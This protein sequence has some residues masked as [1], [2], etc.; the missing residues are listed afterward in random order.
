MIKIRCL[1][2]SGSSLQ[3][4]IIVT[5]KSIFDEYSI[6]YERLNPIS[7]QPWIKDI[8]NADI[9]VLR[10]PANRLISL[11][12]SHGW[13]HQTDN[14][15][16]DAFELREEI[17]SQNLASWMTNEGVLGYTNQVY[18][19]IIDLKEECIIRY[20]DIMD[21]GK[22]YLHLLLDKINRLD[23][24]DALWDI[25]SCEFNCNVEDQ[26]DK[27]YN[28]Q[29]MAHRRNLDHKE[30]L[31]KLNNKQLEIIYNEMGD[32]I[33]RYNGLRNRIPKV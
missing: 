4:R 10:H 32:I 6:D 12:Y 9:V 16:K 19:D 33:H 14:F 30:Y 5:L 31:H 2:K 20:E 7:S 24:L 23:L 15:N 18:T 21:N 22:G 17:R 26:S 25:Y 11:Y 13:T 1:N 3:A 28:G 27:I 8:V 29:S